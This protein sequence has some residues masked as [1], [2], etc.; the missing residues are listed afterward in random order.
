MRFT[1]VAGTF[2][3]LACVLGAAAPAGAR[4]IDAAAVSQRA[5]VLRAVASYD[6]MQEHM[7]ADDGSGL[8]RERYPSGAEDRTYSFEWPHSQAHVATLDLTGLPGA[9]GRSFQDDLADVARGQEH[10][11]NAESLFT[12]GD[13]RGP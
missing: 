10:F 11:W 12:R 4:E 1:R 7:A 2:V 13:V 8:Y 6:A 9:A 5:Q 3:A